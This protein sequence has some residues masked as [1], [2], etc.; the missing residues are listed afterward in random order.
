MRHGPERYE[1]KVVSPVL[2]KKVVHSLCNGSTK[3]K[4]KLL[5]K[6]TPKHFG[7]PPTKEIYKKIMTLIKKGKKI[8]KAKVLSEDITFSEEAQ[9]LLSK[10]VPILKSSDIDTVVTSLDDYRKLRLLYRGMKKT[11][12]YLKG[13]SED[14]KDV[15]EVLSNVEKIIGEAR[16]SSL[17]HLSHAGANDNSKVNLKRI[18]DKDITFIPTGIQQFD[19]VNG[20]LFRGSLL[21]IAASSSGGKTALAL[22]LAINAYIKQGINVCYISLEMDEDELWARTYANL[23][24]IDHDI[25]KLKRFTAKQANYMKKVREKFVEVGKKRGKTFTLFCPQHDMTYSELMLQ[26][27]PYNYDMIILDYVNLVKPDSFSMQQAQQLG[28]L[29]RQG[30]LYAS[31]HNCISVF[32]A[33]LN[34]EDDVKYSGAIFEHSTMVWKWRYGDKARETHIVDVQV[35]KAR[36]QRVQINPP[37]KL[38]EEFQFMSF[39]DASDAEID[40]SSG[41]R[42]ASDSDKMEYDEDDL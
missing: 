7:Y 1:M 16:Q 31:S 14:E 26:V 21:T 30:K 2:E 10:K 22:Q 11:I 29:A 8:P 3:L 12:T 40:S 19:D 18:L 41:V 34:K 39:T 32:L 6:M 27:E 25:I 23:C 42:T 36:N 4:S 37:L 24:R 9:L 20:G 15:D 35:A 5:R 17:V 13:S 28:D 33:Q 38:K